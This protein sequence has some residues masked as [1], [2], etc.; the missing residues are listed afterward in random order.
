VPKGTPALELTTAISRHDLTDPE[1]TWHSEY[2]R[3]VVLPRD[4]SLRYDGQR[5]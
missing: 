3:E 1:A 2:K 4:L 5:S